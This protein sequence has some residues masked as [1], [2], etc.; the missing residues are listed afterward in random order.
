MV[1]FASISFSTCIW[2][3]RASS[4]PVS[5]LAASGTSAVA[6]HAF[7]A[8]PLGSASASLS[9]L[10]DLSFATAFAFGLA[11]S[12]FSCTTFKVRTE[13]AS[14]EFPLLQEFPHLA[15][16]STNGNCGVLIDDGVHGDVFSN[17]N[18]IWVGE[19]LF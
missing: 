7:L 11:F 13:E 14:A 17:V 18:T 8:E 16:V 19:I 12:E 3:V 1:A 5:N 10:A 9:F 6:D 15:V 4:R 2:L